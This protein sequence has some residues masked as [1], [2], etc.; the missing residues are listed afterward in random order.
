MLGRLGGIVALLAVAACAGEPVIEPPATP[1][2]DAPRAENGAAKKDV[3]AAAL[4]GVVLIV[5][6]LPN[7]AIAYGAGIVLD[8]DGRVLT[9]LHVV[10]H[11]R[12]LGAMFYDPTRHGYRPQD[13]GLQRYLFENGK[14][15]HPAVLQRG[16][17]QT[18]LAI[19]KVDA[20]TSKYPRLAFR[21]TPA[22]PGEHVLAV[23]H[24][25][26]SAWSFTAGV[27]SQRSEGAIHTDPAIHGSGGPL[28]DV[29]GHVVGIGTSPPAGETFARPA[30]VAKELLET[31]QGGIAQMDMSTPEKAFTSCRRAW[32]LGSE[33]VSEC[34][35][36][37]SFAKM[38]RAVTV[39]ILEK[40][41]AATVVVERARKDAASREVKE[42]AEI[43]R[44]MLVA[45]A[46]G[47]P[48]REAAKAELG[49]QRAAATEAGLAAASAKAYA[50]AIDRARYERTG[51]KVDSQNPNALRDL[52]KLGT[53]VE[54]V[55][56][57]GESAWLLVSGRN[58]DATPY[59]YSELWFHRGDR[60]VPAATVMPDELATLPRGFP[61]P[62][63]DFES[64]VAASAGTLLGPGEHVVIGA[65]ADVAPP[66]PPAPAKKPKKPAKPRPPA[67]PRRK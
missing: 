18:D 9:N 40:N 12:T 22:Q 36:D 26:E 23:G 60:W 66:A 50:A 33:S 4:P 13:G 31:A 54:S 3:V 45:M 7:G 56:R 30:A 51:M 63:D 46:R 25:G 58:V 11:A 53:R 52:R 24:S 2:G 38:S 37:E 5:N 20:D 35:D 43:R 47:V 48:T 59:R 61:P 41:H 42:L 1:S 65:V 49:L 32:E 15:L 34:F 28:L 17:P 44:K 19:I 67:T 39:A 27:V 10:A 8:G 57:R 55:E 6:E 21:R 62:V 16:E 14:D 64:T 29:H